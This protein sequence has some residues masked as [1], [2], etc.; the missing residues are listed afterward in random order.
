MPNHP[1]IQLINALRPLRLPKGDQ[2][3]RCDGGH[4]AGK[5]EGIALATADYPVCRIE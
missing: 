3:S 4:L 2:P 5:L 1:N